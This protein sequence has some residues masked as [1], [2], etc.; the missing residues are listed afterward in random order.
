[1]V[2]VVSWFLY[3]PRN[4]RKGEIHFSLEHESSDEFD[5]V[6]EARFNFIG[7]LPYLSIQEGS[8]VRYVVW[9][10]GHMSFSDDEEEETFRLEYSDFNGRN[11]QKFKWRV[12]RTFGCNDKY[13]ESFHCTVCEE[14]DSTFTSYDMCEEDYKKNSKYIKLFPNRSV[15]M[16]VECFEYD[17][18]F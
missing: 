18:S 2:K 6:L 8:F 14:S 15:T 10:F 4:C 17:Q 12:Y 9:E 5:N 11:N 13:S 16:Q 1:M 7:S 3:V